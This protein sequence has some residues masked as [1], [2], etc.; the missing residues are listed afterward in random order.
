MLGKLIAFPD[1][2]DGYTAVT[3]ERSRV[4]DALVRSRF[5]WLCIGVIGGFI[6]GWF[7]R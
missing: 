4:V 1:G 6:I 3:L 2:R 5:F 7:A